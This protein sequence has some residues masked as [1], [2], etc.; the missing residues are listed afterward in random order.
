MSFDSPSRRPDDL[1]ASF[2]EIFRRLRVLESANRLTSASIGSGGLRILDGGS[3]TV[4]GPT[5]VGGDLAV[6]GS[7]DLTG[8]LSLTA[9]LTVGTNGDIILSGGELRLRSGSSIILEGGSLTISGDGTYDGMNYVDS[10]N[11]S[12]SG[13]NGLTGSW[14]TLAS[15]T[16]A[17]PTWVNARTMMATGSVSATPLTSGGMEVRCVI[18]GSGGSVASAGWQDHDLSLTA[19]HSVDSGA[20]GTVNYSVQAREVDGTIEAFHASVTCLVVGTA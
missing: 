12:W 14:S 6:S 5:D 18:E 2:E 20:G 17:V 13:A 10:A 4:D 15:G 16:I 1:V 3:L 8:P 11:A 7:T 19:H 9:D